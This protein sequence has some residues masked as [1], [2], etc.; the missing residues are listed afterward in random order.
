MKSTTTTTQTD[1][2]GDILP[3]AGAASAAALLLAGG[4]LALGRRR[5]ER[6]DA[7]YTPE[8]VTTP[9]EPATAP[10]APAPTA[11]AAPPMSARRPEAIPAKGPVAAVPSGF[12]ISRF[13][14]HTQ[15]A[16]RGPTPENPSQSLKRRLKRA[17]FF[18]QRE[19]MATQGDLPDAGDTPAS[20]PIPATGQRHAGY[21]TTKA[22]KPPRP[23]FRPAYQS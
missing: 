19:R 18:D 3:I 5:R 16:Y 15:A 7:I 17:S 12:D 13:G 22:P 4:A 10:M 2:T 8:A 21:V 20:S 11:Y 14:R 9:V 1:P 23:T 6:E